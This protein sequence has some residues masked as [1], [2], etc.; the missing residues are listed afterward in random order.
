[1]HANKARFVSAVSL[2]MT[3]LAIPKSVKPGAKLGTVIE[4]C[5]GLPGMEPILPLDL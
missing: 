4:R 3:Q 1:M 2:D 5:L